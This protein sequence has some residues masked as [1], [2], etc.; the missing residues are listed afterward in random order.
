FTAP[1]GSRVPIRH[2]GGEA[3]LAIRVQELFGL[4]RHPT[5][6]DGVPLTLELLSPAQRP[7]QKPR[8]LPGFRR[9]SWA[10]VRA[11]MRGRYPKHVWPEDPAAAAPTHRAKPRNK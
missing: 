10:D 6:G 4:T 9:G 2:E 8:D 3:V 7:V 1:T 5:V 11:D